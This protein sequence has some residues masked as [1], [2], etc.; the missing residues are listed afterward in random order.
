MKLVILH[1]VPLG[2]EKF[3]SRER[4]SKSY[5]SV[6]FAISWFF[7]EMCKKMTSFGLIYVNIWNFK[8]IPSRV[9]EEFLL[10]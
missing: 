6:I 1:V 10:A 7:P 2:I 9:M 8:K 5:E 4:E 3:L